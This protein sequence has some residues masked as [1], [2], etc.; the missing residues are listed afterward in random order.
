MPIKK[1]VFALLMLM[2][3]AMQQAGGIGYDS[4]VLPLCFWLVAYIFHL[5]FK[6]KI[7]LKD[8]I[9]LIAVWAIITYIKMPYGFLILLM[10]IFP[11]DRIDIRIGKLRIDGKVIRKWRIPVC[12]LGIFLLAVAVYCLR[13]HYYINIVIGLFQEWKRTLYLLKETV[14]NWTG[15][16]VV[17]SV[18]NFG[19]LDTPIHKGVAVLVYIIIAGIAVVTADEKQEEKLRKWDK[20]VIWGTFFVSCLFTVFA[21]V[22]H[23]IMVTLFGSEWSPETYEIRSALYQI[24]YIG[25]LQGRYFL[26]FISLLFLPLSQVKR[27]SAKKTRVA[28]A[29]FESV[30][31]IYIMYILMCRYWIA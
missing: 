26:P 16:L 20:I 23:T 15:M 6:D 11:A 21:M 13:N 1:E 29:V 7:V 22:N 28:V 17:S 2:P 10:L 25:G 31:F 24:P 4:V 9:Y 30:M 12:I 5:R 18:G 19:W 27:V 3:M 14:R 8:F